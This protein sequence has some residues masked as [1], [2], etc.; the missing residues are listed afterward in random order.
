[1]KSNNMLLRQ[2]DAALHAMELSFHVRV[3]AT[4]GNDLVCAPANAESSQWIKVHGADFDQFPVK[5]GIET[6]GVLHAHKQ[7]LSDWF[8]K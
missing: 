5:N 2:L 7:R 6:V 4:F 1:M 3:I 8:A